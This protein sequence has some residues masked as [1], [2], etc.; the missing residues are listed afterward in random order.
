MF[1]NGTP[2]GLSAIPVPYCFS[3]RQPK[4][5]RIQGNM[6]KIRVDIIHRTE[7]SSVKCRKSE[8][9]SKTERLIAWNGVN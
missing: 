8:N 3:N 5:I 4:S 9:R 7:V 1:Y 6:S 2:V